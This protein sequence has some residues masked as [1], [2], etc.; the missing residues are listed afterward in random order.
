MPFKAAYM[1]RPGAIVPLHGIKSRTRAY[2]LAYTFGWPLVRLLRIL[3]PNQV[4]TT[5]EIGRA[6][7]NV[8]DR[9]FPKKILESADIRAAS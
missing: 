2:R 9:G 3:F 5:E 6:M 1:F 8:A 7:I 4:L